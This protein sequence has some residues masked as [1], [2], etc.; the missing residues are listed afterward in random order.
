M[1]FSA[2]NIKN[3]NYDV[4]LTLNEEENADIKKAI[5]EFSCGLSCVVSKFITKHSDNEEQALK[6][7]EIIKKICDDGVN[8]YLSTDVFSEIK[9]LR[10]E[11]EMYQ[12]MVD[13]FD[14]WCENFA[15]IDKS[16]FLKLY[17]K[18][19]SLELKPIVVK[20]EVSIFLVGDNHE[21]LLCSLSNFTENKEDFE[22]NCIATYLI[23][24]VAGDLIFGEESNPIRK[25][26]EGYDGG[27]MDTIISMIE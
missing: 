8:E 27:L 17:S 12:I 15:G 19:K 4:N 9:E 1:E 24:V 3:E 5:F 6:L 23:A 10:E 26:Y 21:E 7:Y 2:S 18:T 25:N 14:D 22:N 20:D 16:D 11:Q 13:T